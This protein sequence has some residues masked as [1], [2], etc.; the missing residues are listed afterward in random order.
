LQKQDLDEQN[1]ASEN[2]LRGAQTAEIPARA[3]L[4]NAEADKDRA[5][6]ANGPDLAT[7]YAH[8]VNQVLRENGDPSTDPTVMYL[9]H[10]ITDIQRKPLPKGL[11]KVDLVGPDG[12]P[13]A[14]NYDPAKG[15]YTDASCK[16]I[17]NPRP[18]EKP[19]Q[20]GMVT[21]VAPDPNNPGG[22][23][24][25]R[26]GAGAHLAPGSMTA[27][28]YGVGAAA[29][30]KQDKARKQAAEE[31]QKDYKLMQTLAANPSP[32]NDLAMVMHYIGA[33][34]PDS[35]GK[36]RLNQNE[37]ALV[38]G[39]RSSFGDLEAM[40]EKVRNGQKLTPEQRNNMLE[41]MRILSASSGDTGGGPQMIR[42]RDPQGVLHE[43]PAGTPLPAGWKAE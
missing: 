15:V 4:E 33:T 39:T 27:S 43:A 16:V 26:V 34:K 25:E 36:L 41:T 12:K 18:Y 40:E 31:A 22:G 9:Q 11:E 14:A 6:V 2:A 24:V 37:I 29:D 38:M 1:A 23:I 3:N 30:V 19:N 10:A 7:A 35:I 5:A 42:A 21:V 13:M 28:Q 32:T 17:P 8:R 20:A